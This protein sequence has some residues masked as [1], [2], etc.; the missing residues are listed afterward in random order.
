MIAAIISHFQ[1]CWISHFSAGSI[2]I[3]SLI[4]GTG[5]VTSVS[6]GLVIFFSTYYLKRFL[7]KRYGVNK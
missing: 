6:A 4:N 1:N 5:F 2:T 7:D 3:L